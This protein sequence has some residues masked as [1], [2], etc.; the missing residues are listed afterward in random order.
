[1]AHNVETMAYAGAVPWH[2]LGKKVLPDLTPD[3]ML[4]EAQLDWEVEKRDVFFLG[5]SG[6]KKRASNKKALVRTSD[7]SF[8]D[9]VSAE[10]NPLQNKEAFE[11]FNDFIN[12]GEMEMHTA[13][14]LQNGNIVWALGKT[15]NN[16]RIFGDDVVDEYLLFTNPHKFG[17]SIQVQSTPIRVVCNNTLSYALQ[18]S[19]GTGA[20]RVNHRQE[21]DADAVKEILGVSKE[22]LDTYKEVAEF[23]GS[24]KFNDASLNGFFGDI[25]PS[26]SKKP[27][28]EF[29]NKEDAYS[30]NHK[31]ALEVMDEQPGAE[32]GKGTF[33]QAFNTVTFMTDHVMGRSADTRL[34]SAWFGANRKNKISALEKA[35]EYAEAA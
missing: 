4:V 24:V 22:K 26:N 9:M 2:G 15:K 11:F 3:Q 1:M 33:W 27:I 30:R 12:A 13:G 34:T 5:N 14:S 25:F 19:T 29:E 10:W 7:G 35:V 28:E 16:F 17:K 6:E 20:V 21:F 23:L 8:L 32:F 31:I 18:T